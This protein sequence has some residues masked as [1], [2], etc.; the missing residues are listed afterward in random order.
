MLVKAAEL[1]RPHQMMV[2]VDVDAEEE[3]KLYSEAGFEICE[4]YNSVLASYRI[5]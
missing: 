5:R 2:L 4:G 1:N 3:I